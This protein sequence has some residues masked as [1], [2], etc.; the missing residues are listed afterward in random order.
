MLLICLLGL[1][2]VAGEAGQA[3]QVG[4][5]FGFLVQEVINAFP[6]VEGLVVS[7][8]G[9]RVYLD[10][11]AKE[12]VQ[13]G[14]EFT[15]FR[16]GDEFRHPISGKV[17][18]RYEDILGYAQIQRVEGRFSEA[19]YIPI[20]GQ[21]KVEAEDGA[22]ITRGR[23]R[24]AVAPPL[25]LT[26]GQ[27]DLRR[28]P[29]MAP[30]AFAQAPPAAPPLTFN[31]NGF[32]D[33]ITSASHNLRDLNFTRPGDKEWYARNRGRFNIEGRAGTA[34]VVWGIEI[35]ST[36]GQVSATDNN[37]AGQVAGTNQQRG[38]ATS[39]FDLNTDTQGSVETKWLFGEFDM[40][41][42][43]GT[44]FEA[45]SPAYP[46]SIAGGGRYDKMI[47]RM[48]NRDVPA[49]GFSIGFERLIGMLTERAQVSG[50]PAAAGAGA[51][52]VAFL[53]DEQGDLTPALAASRALRAGGDQVS[54]Q[55][56]RKNL[57][58][59][60]E[61]LATHGFTAYAT[62]EAGGTPIVKPLM[63]RGRD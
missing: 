19:L 18:G 11:T 9:D 30:G 5:T 45:T 63:R 7:V 44:I 61:T 23:I 1:V 4:A 47:G 32:L 59:Q 28:V 3:D 52:R 6:P 46:S 17:L 20:P 24:V 10:L 55:V 2:G 13:R 43:T 35:D 26:K 56:K 36:W 39:G 62:C 37:L 12:G 48:I 50:A 16:K 58:K 51:R 34:V 15:L 27:K 38:G 40:G 57:G 21:P 8:D 22:R 49:C 29:F 42:Y 53:V 14:Q 25:D 54:L 33:T 31:I 60:L 41:Y